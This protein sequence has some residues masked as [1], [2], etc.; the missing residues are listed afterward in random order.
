[1]MMRIELISVVVPVTRDLDVTSAYRSYR[2]VL[3]S[4][5]KPVEFIYVLD[6]LMP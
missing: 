1:M 6:G 5:G 2:R 3:A 4:F